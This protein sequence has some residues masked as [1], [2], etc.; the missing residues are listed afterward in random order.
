MKLFTYSRNPNA[1]RISV[2]ITCFRCVPKMLSQ[3]LFTEIKQTSIMSLQTGKFWAPTPKGRPLYG[4]RDMELLVSNNPSCL[5]GGS[6]PFPPR[7][8][9]STVNNPEF[10]ILFPQQIRDKILACFLPHQLMHYLR[11]MHVLRARFVEDIQNE[12]IQ[13]PIVI[14]I[15]VERDTLSHIDACIM[16]SKVESIISSAQWKGE[17]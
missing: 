5:F 4:R 15:L 16:V 17:K 8:V 10:E 7:K 6:L 12:G 14:H 9:F 1:F 2:G 11:S 3:A 13:N